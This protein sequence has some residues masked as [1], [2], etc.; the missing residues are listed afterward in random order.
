MSACGREFR[1]V[2]MRS[3]SSSFEAAGRGSRATKSHMCSTDSPRD[4]LKEVNDFG[5]QHFTDVPV[6][7][8]ITLNSQQIGSSM[9]QN[10]TPN[11][12]AGCVR[13]LCRSITHPGRQPLP[14]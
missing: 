7:I 4:S 3:R 10:R 8:E 14:A 2:R 5:L 6:A 9:I 13:P 1:I 12:N 11:H